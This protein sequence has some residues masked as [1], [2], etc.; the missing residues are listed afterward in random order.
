MTELD[1]N[2][3]GIVIPAN[4]FIRL[5]EKIIYNFSDDKKPHEKIARENNVKKKGPK[6]LLLVDDAGLIYI[7]NNKVEFI[8]G[9]SSVEIKGDAEEARIKTVEIA[10]KLLGNDKATGSIPEL[11]FV[12]PNK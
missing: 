11:N 2:L 7:Y 5:G 1:R 3:E 8:R 4:R 10:R 6:G 9:C 12:V